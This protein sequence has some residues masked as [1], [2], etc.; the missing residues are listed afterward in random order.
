MGQTYHLYTKKGAFEPYFMKKCTQN[1]SHILCAYTQV[2]I[3]MSFY[4]IEAM[5]FQKIV[6]RRQDLTL[7]CICEI[8]FFSK[9]NVYRNLYINKEKLRFSKFQRKNTGKFVVS[10]KSEDNIVSRT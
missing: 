3:K 4:P 1:Y 6:Y 9:E 10:G 5:E 7:I 8:I 2:L